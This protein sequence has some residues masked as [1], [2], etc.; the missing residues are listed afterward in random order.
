MKKKTA[1]NLIK[2]MLLI[3]AVFVIGYLIYT[4][5]VT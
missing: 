4:F 2:T 1:K 5:N 3:I